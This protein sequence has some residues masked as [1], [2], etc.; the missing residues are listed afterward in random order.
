M[1]IN[2][3]DALDLVEGFASGIY[4]KDV[5]GQFDQC[6]VG[7]PTF[8]FKIYHAIADLKITN[9]GDLFKEWTKLTNLIGVVTE[10]IAEAP[11]D[12]QACED[13]W[14]EITGTFNWIMHH[15]SLT[16]IFGSIFGNLSTHMIKF[17]SES[18][19]LVMDLI[20]H[21]FYKFGQDLGIIIMLLLA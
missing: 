4:N 13:I 8:G 6:I 21:N 19:A 12:I 20:K 2:N 7:L 1:G 10:I 17:A 5:R 14:G 11:E 3:V 9:F 18:W 15:L 16:T